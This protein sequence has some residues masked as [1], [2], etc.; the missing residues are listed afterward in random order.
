MTKEDI[1]VI[2]DF[3][4]DN[5]SSQLEELVT[6]HHFPWYFNESHVSERCD[7]T[8]TPD[9]GIYQDCDIH[10]GLSCKN[11]AQFTHML[12]QDN[13]VLSSHFN[14]IALSIIP[15]LPFAISEFNRMKLNFGA[16]VTLPK[17]IIGIPHI[18][19]NSTVDAEQVWIGLYYVNNSD[20]DTHLFEQFAS[21]HRQGDDLT[22]A[23]TV[24]PKRGRIVI[25]N[26]D[27]I[28]ASNFT[29]EHKSRIVVNFQ[30]MLTT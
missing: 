17:N 4:P 25:F 5:I 19:A 11:E 20:G 30:F 29:R 27:R 7:Q 3:L 1:I 2:D 12:F 6:Q 22:I 21:T 23:Q 28:H 26:N 8:E 9:Y 10:G 15:K 13:E 14:T 16:R 18:D 24:T